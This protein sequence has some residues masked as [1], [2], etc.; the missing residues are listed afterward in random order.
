[1]L[2]LLFSSFIKDYDQTQITAYCQGNKQCATAK[3][4][5]TPTTLAQ[6]CVTYLALLKRLTLV[7]N[8]KVDLTGVFLQSNAK[9]PQKNISH[10]ADCR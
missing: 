1:M 8:T 6:K 3:F 2:Q 5:T 7:R 4:D 10:V 9:V